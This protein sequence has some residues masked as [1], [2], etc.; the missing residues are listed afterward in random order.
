[1]STTLPALDKLLAFQA[2]IR[3]VA[4]PSISVNVDDLALPWKT[5]HPKYFTSDSLWGILKTTETIYF[6]ALVASLER[7]MDDF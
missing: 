4:L 5:G 6:W 1:M 3:V 7:I 2:S